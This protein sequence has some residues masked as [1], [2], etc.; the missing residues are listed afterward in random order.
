MPSNTTKPEGVVTNHIKVTYINHSTVLIQVDSLNIITDPV[1]AT[2]ASPVSFAGPQRKKM[3][4]VKLE[5]LPPIDIILISHNHYDHLDLETLKQI[6]ANHKPKIIAPLGVGQF[7]KE[8]G[9]PVFKDMD[10][11]QNT[12]INKKVA[13]HCLPAQHFSGRGF[14]DRDATLWCSY[15]IETTRGNIYFAGDTGYGLFFREISLKFPNINLALIPIGA[16]K[17]EWF[18]SPIHIS[19]DEAVRVHI[20]LKA[21]QSMGIHFG[22]FPLGDDGENDPPLDLKAALKKYQIDSNAFK[23]P[24]NGDTITVR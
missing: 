13:I 24:A 5:D 1:W 12:T 11:W 8:N 16:Y 20:D 22:T 21:K 7:L 10:W 9:M 17:P 2:R 18:M 4:G 6:V 15:M 23:I 19:P 3:P 14:A